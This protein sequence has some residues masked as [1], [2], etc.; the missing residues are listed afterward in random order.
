MSRK[1]KVRL[2]S[3]LIVLFAWEFYGRRTNPILFTY[4]T[5][6]ARAFFTLVATG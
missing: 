2:V 4:P 5:A 6:V 1:S 3:L